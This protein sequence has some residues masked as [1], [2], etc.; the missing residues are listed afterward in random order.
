MI[1]SLGFTKNEAKA[2]EVSN[3]V[4]LL[5]FLCENKNGKTHYAYV[6]LYLESFRE[7]P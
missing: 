6:Y 3:M 2:E 4:R 5:A 1:Y 7:A